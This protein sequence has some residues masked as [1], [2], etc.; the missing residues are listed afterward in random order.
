VTVVDRDY[1]FQPDDY[2]RR[3][4]TGLCV[5]CGEDQ[6]LPDD[7]VCKDCAIEWGVFEVVDVSE[8]DE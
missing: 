7:E 5:I 3:I 1:G 4:S 6:A 8:A 2:D